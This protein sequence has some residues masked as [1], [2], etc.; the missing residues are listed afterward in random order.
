M[1]NWDNEARKPGK[2]HIFD[3]CSPARYKSWLRRCFDF[4][5]S[6]NVES[7][8][9]VFVNAWNEW[10][11]GTYLEPDRRYGYAYLHATADLLRNYYRPLDIDEVIKKNNLR[12][13][14]RYDTVLV[15]HRYYFDLLPELKNLISP[16]SKLD[17]F[18]T[19]PS[20]I[21]REQV[22]IIISSFE[23]IYL[24]PVENKGRDIYPFLITLRI[25]KDYG[26][27]YVIKVHSKKSPQRDDGAVL[28]QRALKELLSENAVE[29][30]NDIFKKYPKLGLIGPSNSMCSLTHFDYLINNQENLK[31]CLSYLNINNLPLDFDFIA[32]SMFWARI[33]A[34]I[35]LCE[36]NITE[37][38]FE[39]ELG[40][41]DGT[42]AH[43]IERL[44]CFIAHRAGYSSHSIDQLNS[45][46]SV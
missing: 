17:I 25:I 39:E 41:L 37:S 8:R 3:G 31:K 36:L 18:M 42:M 4:V 35:M 28:R 38:D 12:F 19:I 26:Y 24:I 21:T 2:G 33:D 14:K 13:Q 11:E 10:A 5:L 15:A 6:S 16:N 23:N 46:T 45:V 7:E 27:L 20:H 32:G 30:I 34:L 1:M 43:A 29:Q 44:F 22:E 40:Q 9:F